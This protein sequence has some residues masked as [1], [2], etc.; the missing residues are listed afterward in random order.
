MVGTLNQMQQSSQ[1]DKEEVLDEKLHNKMDM[2]YMKDFQVRRPVPVKLRQKSSLQEM[3]SAKRQTQIKHVL[4]DTNGAQGNLELLMRP[5]DKRACQ[6]GELHEKTHIR[7]KKLETLVLP[8]W[9]QILSKKQNLQDASSQQEKLDK[10][11]KEQ[12]GV[13]RKLQQVQRHAEEISSLQ[14][15]QGGT[16]LEKHRD[17]LVSE[18][19]RLKQELQ[20]LR[21]R[22]ECENNQELKALKQRLCDLEQEEGERKLLISALQR[23]VQQKSER[24]AE[25]E[26][27][28]RDSVREKVEEEERLSRI[29]REHQLSQQPQI[30]YVVK[31]VEVESEK[32]KSALSQAQNHSRYLQEQIDIQRQALQEIQEQLQ[33]EQKDA[34]HLR[35]QVELYEQELDQSQAQM[36]QE[37]QSLQE[38][39]EQAV[40]DAFK[41]AQ[42]EMRAV[43]YSLDGVRK[44][45]LT[46]QPALR[47]LTYDYNALKRQVREFPVMLHEAMSDAHKEFALAVQSVRDTNTELLRKYQRELQL[48]KECHNQLVRLRGNIRVLARVRPITPEDGGGA[49]AQNVV[50]FDHDDDGI[51]YVTHKGKDLSFELDRVF[52]PHA[53]QEEVFREVSPLITSCLDGYSVCI[54]AYGQTGSGK[55]YSME[56]ISS[57][58]G[59]NQ[60]ALQLLLANVKERSSAWEHQMSVSM[61]EIY[62]ESLRDLLGT[63]PQSSLDIKISPGSGGELYVPGLTQKSVQ[64]MQD[65]NKILDMGH[66]QRATDNTN[67]NAHSS[68]SHAMLILTAKGRETSTGI[69]T[70]GKLYLVDLAGSERVSRSGAAGDRLREAQCINRSLSALGDVFSALRSQQGHVPYRNSK[71]T[72]LL[73]EPLSRDGKALLLLQV[74]P[75]EKNVNESLCSLR[76]GDRVRAVELG[77]PARKID[78]SSPSNAES[79]NASPRNSKSTSIRRK[80]TSSVRH[81]IGP[82]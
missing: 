28:L 18:N 1:D 50:N 57:D 10:K 51:L 46:L 65:I 59:I 69:C 52:T 79:E 54:L 17:L 35:Q 16:D 61:V 75:A 67:L 8:E 5:T 26:L 73:Q 74:S 12:G 39:K 47:T 34:A 68:R 13:C 22:I 76:F 53:T 25:A 49:G 38:E 40:A 48:R 63:D 4:E 62:N 41:R 82:P 36:V 33:R 23:E 72:Y 29:I 37:Y 64:S 20:I 77:A 3:L 21:N 58:P 45:L 19:E 6:E 32:M 27:R 11:D 71:L 55:T 31:T 66:K 2:Q 70:T 42:E 60:R 43:H 9:I 24:L 30:K 44:N 81:R 14:I 78:V 15:E 80:P 56:G 7:E